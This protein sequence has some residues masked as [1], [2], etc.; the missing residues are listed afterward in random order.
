MFFWLSLWTAVASVDLFLPSRGLCEADGGNEIAPWPCD[1][2]VRVSKDARC[3]DDRTPL[4][5]HCI[6]G[7]A[8]SF[9]F[10]PVFKS[11]KRN[12]IESF[13]G[14]SVT[15]LHLKTFALSAKSPKGKFQGNLTADITSE[16]TSSEYRKLESALHYLQPQHM[17]L[18]SSRRSQP[19]INHDCALEY[20][21]G[22]GNIW[23]AAS[24]YSSPAGVA[25][26]LGQITG[27]MQCLTDI[28]EWE[29]RHSTKFDW[30]VRTRP[31]L[32]FMAPILPYCSFR[33][34]SNNAAFGSPEVR[35]RSLSPSSLWW[36]GIGHHWVT[37]L[38][39]LS[40]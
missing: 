15:F 24:R 12:L 3:G 39:K 30:I 17:R 31:D 35:A 16:W 32:G 20:A 19:P 7:V 38:T 1:L 36:H 29:N 33:S 14:R 8:R 26:H 2:P 22:S 25:R 21:P 28:E 9:L 27:S 4:V 10:E 11:L 37:L 6:S 40:Q 34:S 13:G 23:V 18:E 5:A